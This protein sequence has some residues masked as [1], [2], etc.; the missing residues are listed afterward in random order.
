MIN[1]NEVVRKAYRNMLLEDDF[2]PPE[3]MQVL[4]RNDFE[5][6]CWSFKPPHAI[7]VGDKILEK[8][9]ATN[10]VDSQKVNHYVESYLF[11]EMGH[12]KYTERD[13]KAINAALSK[14]KIPFSL[15]NLFE[16]ARIEHLIR[17]ETGRA[18]KWSELENIEAPK[19]AVGL[20][21]NLIQDEAGAFENEVLVQ[22]LAKVKSENATLPDSKLKE[23]DVDDVAR[24]YNRSL[25]C[26]NSWELI[27]L[28]VEWMKRFPETES[29]AKDLAEQKGGEGQPKEGDG[30]AG[31]QKPKPVRGLTELLE[32]MALQNDDK[33][34]EAAMANSKDIS[35]KKEKIEAKC[36]PGERE[37]NSMSLDDYT[38]LDF[39]RFGQSHEAS[40][41]LANKLLPK[42][43]KLFE[44][45]SQK[46]NT[47]APA[48]RLNTRGLVADSDKIYR[49]KKEVASAKK[50]ICVVIDCSGSMNGEPMNGAATLVLILSRLAQK[51]KLDGHVTLSCTS[52][53]QTFALPMSKQA[54]N[55]H[56]T[57]CGGEGLSE[58][59]RRI[60]PL[61][62]KAD[63]N[64]VITDGN[65]C[66][67]P[68][69][70]RLLNKEGIQTMGI[71]VGDPTRCKLSEWFD[72]GCAR[73]SLSG[74][75][76]EL[77]RKI[78]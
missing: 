7:F 16:D 47:V 68:I 49:A 26:K 56:F 76:D 58:T 54:I 55:E 22:Y 33:A 10:M 9:P 74:L 71:Y 30:N 77:V 29:E 52:G 27:P 38:N 23:E 53:Y 13:F 41:E 34:F 63:W 40:E 15:F 1:I 70:K 8:V 51:N 32:G 36:E 37:L 18:F 21:F 75:V 19:S 69:D 35:D 12:A 60:K 14:E 46:I 64:F 39:S 24:F 3:K 59:F 6:A 48:K 31:G 5:T 73:D 25:G 43:E 61:M 67:E 20:Y 11:H 72:K 17:G 78:K 4:I 62:K 65:I 45:K 50:N 57:V 2:L 44:S 66:D 28:M 42:F